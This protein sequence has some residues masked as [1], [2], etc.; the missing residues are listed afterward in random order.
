MLHTGMRM[1]HCEQEC[2]WAKSVGVEIQVDLAIIPGILAY[3]P[4]T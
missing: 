1:L 2:R 4:S 3:R